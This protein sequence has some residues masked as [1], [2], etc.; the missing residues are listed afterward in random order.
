MKQYS[1]PHPPYELNYETNEEIR[2]RIIQW[3]ERIK[4][5]RK[6]EDITDYWRTRNGIK[7]AIQNLSNGHCSYCG[8]MV[9]CTIDHYLPKIPFRFLAYCWDNLFPSCRSCN[10]AKSRYVPQELQNR[11]LIDPILADREDFAGEA[12]H[13]TMLENIR[14]RIFHP[15]VDNP[16][17][18]IDFDVANL[19][20][21]AKEGSSIGNI[22]IGLI[23]GI[24]HEAT[25]FAE[26]IG[27]RVNYIEKLFAE[28]RYQYNKILELGLAEYEGYEFIVRKA[29]DY[30]AQFY[31]NP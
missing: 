17:A 11:E 30:W 4:T 16:E 25:E 1:R 7:K 15:I 18:H 29:V 10:E 28:Q 24:R 26:E 31:T 22:T 20:F 6:S 3:Y 2:E 12:F 19:K 14:E 21:I 9:E 23:L 5:K 13:H 27:Y 8:K